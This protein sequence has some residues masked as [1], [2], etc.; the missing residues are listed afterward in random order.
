M[1]T[2]WRQWLPSVLLM[3]LAPSQWQPYHHRPQPKC[4]DLANNV[5]KKKQKGSRKNNERW[6]SFLPLFPM[7]EKLQ[8]RTNAL[9]GQNYVYFQLEAMVNSWQKR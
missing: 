7:M 8:G 2:K 5:R 6:V 3:P 4:R 9:S 1:E